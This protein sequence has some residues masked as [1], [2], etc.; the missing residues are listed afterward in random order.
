MKFS[1]FAMLVATVSAAPFSFSLFASA[2][3]DPLSTLNATIDSKISETMHSIEPQLERI[4]MINGTQFA[5]DLVAEFDHFRDV[6]VKKVQTEVA[7][8]IAGAKSAG[9]PLSMEDMMKLVDALHDQLDHLVQVEVKDWSEKE[10]KAWA[11]KAEKAWVG[12]ERPV[13]DK[14]RQFLDFVKR[15]SPGRGSSAYVFLFL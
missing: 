8:A 6:I 12:I 10:L 13:V 4:L 7:E 15:H 2:P 9:V 3:V 11:Q 5:T 14:I 1:A